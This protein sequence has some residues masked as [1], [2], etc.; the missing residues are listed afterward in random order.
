MDKVAIRM[1]FTDALK[2]RFLT[3][4]NTYEI[5]CEQRKHWTKSSCPGF[6]RITQV[7]YVISAEHYAI[8]MLNEELGGFF[9][10]NYEVEE[11]VV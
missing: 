4:L 5:P 3:R 11:G 10:V 9:K 2:T 1:S 6:N 8:F 7:E